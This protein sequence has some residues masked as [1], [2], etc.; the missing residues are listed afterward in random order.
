MGFS[1]RL[2]AV[3]TTLLELVDDDPILAVRSWLAELKGD[4]STVSLDTYGRGLSRIVTKARGAVT[5]ATASELESLVASA[6]KSID[7]VRQRAD[8]SGDLGF[9]LGSTDSAPPRK[10]GSM[11]GLSGINASPP[12]DVARLDEVASS[13]SDDN[14]C[15][16]L[17]AGFAA[18]H[19]GH[20]TAHL[21][22]PPLRLYPI[23]RLVE[24]L[25]T[26]FAE[27]AN[28]GSPMREL[29][30]NAV[31]NYLSNAGS[32]ELSTDALFW[33]LFH[34]LDPKDPNVHV[35]RAYVTQVMKTAKTK[36]PDSLL[37]IIC[38]AA[39][40]CSADA[41]TRAYFYEWLGIKI[42]SPIVTATSIAATLDEAVSEKELIDET[43]K[44]AASES[45]S[46]LPSG[47]SA[48]SNHL[49]KLISDGRLQNLL[50][51]IPKSAFQNTDDL[52]NTLVAFANV[53]VVIDNA[54]WTPPEPKRLADEDI[55]A[56]MEA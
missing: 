11:S 56:L 28:F 16:W 1:R 33:Q 26:A 39:W 18:I 40:D 32:G 52:R 54:T 27:A 42:D 9:N 19:E 10:E 22:F 49:D 30:R 46:R 35:G 31:G 20:P 23:G 4:E 50:L 6:Q 51:N 44:Y 34:L 7:L 8:A 17:S 25:A 45:L 36:F 5:A 15:E 48:I 38:V 14:W 21:A 55:R 3:F 12:P 24:Q 41:S 29:I 37:E 47:T 43:L 13:W 53:S 2:S